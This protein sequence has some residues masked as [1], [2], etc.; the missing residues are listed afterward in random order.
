MTDELTIAKMVLDLARFFRYDFK[1]SDMSPYIEE[2]RDFEPEEI[3]AAI[4]YLMRKSKFF[5]RPIEISELI[6]PNAST[7]AR[8]EVEYIFQVARNLNLHYWPEQKKKMSQI[9]MHLIQT[10]GGIGDISN[11]RD[12][13]IGPA[14]S[15]MIAIATEQI[16]QM[17]FREQKKLSERQAQAQKLQLVK[18]LDDDQNL[19][20]S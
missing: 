9:Q 16:K 7:L 12:S 18:N 14:K 2:L 5:P 8:L 4:T 3:N 6:A 1:K 19:L 13:D 10:L 17:D 15:R 20:E 11:L